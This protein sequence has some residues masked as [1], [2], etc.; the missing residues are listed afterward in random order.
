MGEVGESRLRGMLAISPIAVAIKNLSNNQRV[1][2]N[3]CMMDM[4]HCTE[5]EAL[6]TDAVHFFQD[7]EEQRAILSQVNAGVTI[8]NGNGEETQNTYG[9]AELGKEELYHLNLN[10]RSTGKHLS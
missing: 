3:Q 2:V 8:R 6:C 7:K 10:N 9:W 5:E 1:F 4:F